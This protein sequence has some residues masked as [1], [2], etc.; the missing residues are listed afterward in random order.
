MKVKR[1]YSPCVPSHQ[2]VQ[3]VH[4]SLGRPAT[5]QSRRRHKTAARH[6][7]HH[8]LHTA[9]L[10]T[11]HLVQFIVTQKYEMCA[12]MWYCTLEPGSPGIPRA[13]SAPARPYKM[14]KFKYLHAYT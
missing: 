3:G 12:G 9:M 4:Q 5:K 13:P 1:L 14:E 7:T 6:H 2:A 11:P 8:G 10:P